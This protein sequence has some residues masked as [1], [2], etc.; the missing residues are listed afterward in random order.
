[1]SESQFE[2]LAL[3]AGVVLVIG[4]GYRLV[5]FLYEVIVGERGARKWAKARRRADSQPFRCISCETLIEP[6]DKQCPGCGL[7]LD[8]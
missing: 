1:M 2:I 5:R 6:A 7:K 8:R 4:V 3:L